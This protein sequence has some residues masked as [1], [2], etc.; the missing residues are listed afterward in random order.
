LAQIL[1]RGSDYVEID[2]DILYNEQGV[3]IGPDPVKRD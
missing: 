2:T 1:L 3:S